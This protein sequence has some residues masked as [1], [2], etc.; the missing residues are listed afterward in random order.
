MTYAIRRQI[1]TGQLPGL[2]IFIRPKAKLVSFVWWLPSAVVVEVVLQL[3][4]QLALL[5][6]LFFVLPD[7]VPGLF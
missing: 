4:Y 3:P 2:V 1:V 7:H 5:P 6:D